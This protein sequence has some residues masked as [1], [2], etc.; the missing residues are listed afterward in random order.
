MKTSIKFSIILAV[1][2][3]LLPCVSFFLMKNKANA[4]KTELTAIVNKL[5]VKHTVE[6]HDK[7]ATT[8]I[9]SIHDTIN[10][11]KIE[12]RTVTPRSI[13]IVPSSNNDNTISLNCEAALMK[14]RNDTLLITIDD[15]S[16]IYHGKI[17]LKSLQTAILNSDTIRFK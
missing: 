6:R 1:V 15:P 17:E 7:N 9:R 8:I 14:L 5:T 3:I 13:Y 16:R 10:C 12:G 11:V 4:A 2:Y